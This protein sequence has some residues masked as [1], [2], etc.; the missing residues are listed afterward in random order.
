[1][2]KAD[3]KIRNNKLQIEKKMRIVGIRV[4]CG[5]TRKN[6][7]KENQEVYRFVKITLFC[8]ETPSSLVDRYQRFGGTS[9]KR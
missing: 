2:L 9:L 1:M 5:N 4:T 3:R 8:N 7:R 6:T